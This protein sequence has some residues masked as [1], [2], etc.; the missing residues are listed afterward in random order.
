MAINQSLGN[1]K[2]LVTHAALVLVVVV[3]V[4]EEAGLEQRKTLSF[5][6]EYSWLLSAWVHAPPR[7]D[8]KRLCLCCASRRMLDALLECT[9]ALDQVEWALEAVMDLAVTVKDSAQRK[10]PSH[11]LPCSQLP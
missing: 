11:P 4:V 8:C 7:K 6:P 5:A 10:T 1:N 2:M 3:V 9:L